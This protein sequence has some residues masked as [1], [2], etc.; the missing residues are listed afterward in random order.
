[1]LARAC[2]G[3]MK[4]DMIM[5]HAFRSLWTAR[6]SGDFAAAAL[7]TQHPGPPPP[8][9][10]VPIDIA[11]EPS[12]DGVAPGDGFRFLPNVAPTDPDGMLGPGT[13]FAFIH[14]AYARV[15]VPI[16]YRLVGR[17]EATDIPIGAI[18]QHCTNIVDSLIIRDPVSRAL[19]EYAFEADA[20]AGV[21]RELLWNFRGCINLKRWVS[22]ERAAERAGLPDE[23]RLSELRP[24]FA[25]LRPS[26][27]SFA[28]RF[29][30]WR[31]DPAAAESGGGGGGGGGMMG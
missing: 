12:I 22:E 29:I 2:F 21:L 15:R 5:L 27:D 8:H 13:W 24:V 16:D 17:A 25:A 20:G 6:F 26:I 28:K 11:N 7:S 4:G 19:G 9:V 30:T 3:G 14:E 1:M 23:Q 18:D 10:A 31:L